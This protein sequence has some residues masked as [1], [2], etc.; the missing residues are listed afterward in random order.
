MD[1]NS[2]SAI[3]EQQTA[4]SL[5]HTEVPLEQCEGILVAR[6]DHCIGCR[7][8]V[9]ACSKRLLD[10]TWT[11]AGMVRIAPVCRNCSSPRCIAACKRGAM[12]KAGGGVVVDEALCVGCG[13]C[14]AACPFG[15]IRAGQPHMPRSYGKVSVLQ[16]IKGIMKCDRCRE[17]RSPACCTEC[18]TGALGFVGGEELSE[19]IRTTAAGSST[20]GHGD[21]Y[22]LRRMKN[23]RVIIG[24]SISMR[25][26]LKKALLA[27]MTAG[28]RFLRSF[29]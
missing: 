24:K 6:A 2:P 5:T 21:D 14:A 3:A 20:G 19:L 13:T 8:C 28:W 27:F 11:D 9:R 15:A 16:P 23:R 10:G 12:H 26:L 25:E 17:R 22:K 7:A 18:P 29:A 4:A 1:I